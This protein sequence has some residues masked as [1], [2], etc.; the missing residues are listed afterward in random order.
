MKKTNNL[1]KI[2]ALLMIQIFLVCFS[3]VKIKERPK[4]ESNY[5]S[6]TTH[7]RTTYEY[8]SGEV[9]ISKSGRESEGIIN[10]LDVRNCDN[11]GMKVKDSYNIR[12]I[13][14]MREIIEI[15][16]DYSNNNTS[17]N[18]WRRTELSMTCEWIIHNVLYDMDIMVNHTGDVDFNNNEFKLFK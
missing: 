8:S 18:M 10:V 7:D 17:D 5:V 11:P 13:K 12:D 2:I 15:L 3:C 4:G 16:I 6:Y 14:A 1:K 9:C